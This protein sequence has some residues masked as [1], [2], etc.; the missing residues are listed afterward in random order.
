MKLKI[1]SSMTSKMAPE[2]RTYKVLGFLHSLQPQKFT[3]H[4]RGFYVVDFIVVKNKKIYGDQFY[5]AA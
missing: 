3:R 5:P 1:D 2:Q 4:S